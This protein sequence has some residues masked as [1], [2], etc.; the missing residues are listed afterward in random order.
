MAD[1]MAK[2][3]TWYAKEYDGASD[4]ARVTTRIPKATPPTT[5]LGM[6]AKYEEIAAIKDDES[7]FTSTLMQQWIIMLAC[8]AYNSDKITWTYKCYDNVFADTKLGNGSP[9]GIYAYF[10]LFT[11]RGLSAF[12]AIYVAEMWLANFLDNLFWTH[13]LILEYFMNEGA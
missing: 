11:W 9:G 12:T 3:V 2:L 6:K 13:V 10:D 7:G 4:I 8:T 5:L 1:F